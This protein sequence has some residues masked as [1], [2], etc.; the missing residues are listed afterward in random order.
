MGKGLRNWC[1]FFQRR[2]TK[3]RLDFC[4]PHLDGLEDR[5]LPSG[6]SEFRIVPDAPLPLGITAGPD[7]ALWFTESGAGKIG[8][9]TPA[10]AVSEYTLPRGDSDPEGIVAGPDGALWFTEFGID[11]IGRIT[12]AGAISE[13]SLAL[14][15][16]P[17]GITAGPG[18]LWFT[19]AA[20][21]RIGR[22]ST[23]G[24]VTE[25]STGITRGSTPT[26]IV[27]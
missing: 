25:F 6:I 7:G 16:G 19:E 8:R 9:I 5:C 4:R 26:G 20:S 2:N 14:N 1:R 3:R 11:R 10:G 24:V 17:R 21:D 27:F 12:T 18:G 23:V 13:F 15:S 22:I